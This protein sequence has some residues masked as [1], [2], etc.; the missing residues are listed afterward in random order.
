M[1]NGH[2]DGGEAGKPEPAEIEVTGVSLGAKKIPVHQQLRGGSCR[3]V[4]EV[5][6]DRGY[7]SM[8][9]DT[10]WFDLEE[11][12]DLRHL[13]AHEVVSEHEGVQLL[14]DAVRRLAAQ[15]HAG[16]PLLS[17]PFIK[18][19]LGFPSPVVEGGYFG[20]GEPRRIRHRGE[21]DKLG[22]ASGV[23]EASRE[24]GL[25]KL[26]I[27]AAGRG[28]RRHLHKLVS[29]SEHLDRVETQRLLAPD[30]PVPILL[31]VVQAP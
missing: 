6:C 28:A 2:H 10:G 8:E 21:D 25:G 20:G 18:G 19:G 11:S 7:G 22:L 1:A 3:D 12:G 23:A 17:L 30:E 16:A 24:E 26:R 9:A 5:V 31:L 13:H 27:L 14:M 29:W 4:V 15:R